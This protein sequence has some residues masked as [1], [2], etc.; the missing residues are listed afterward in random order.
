MNKVKV[1]M[2]PY[3]GA[4]SCAYYNW[5]ELF[6]KELIPVFIELCGRGTREYESFYTSISAASEDIA[7][8]IIENTQDCDYIIFGH[9]MGGLITYET[10]YK[11][12][13]LHWKK[14]LHLF[15]SGQRPPNMISKVLPCFMY[16]DE[17]FIKLVAKYGGLPEE[18][19][20]EEIKKVFLPILRADFSI[21]DEYKVSEKK[22][23]VMCNISILYGEYDS[24]TKESE[25][26]YWNEY[27][28]KEIKFYKFN[29][30]H[31]FIKD[32]YP[33]IISLMEKAID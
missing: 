3:A 25:Q 5:K 22:E 32:S 2:I 9:S 18:F 12:M 20:D 7:K 19:Y 23:K 1:F 26:T 27:A 11:L 31:F 14:P 30:E 16:S 33:Q 24:N 8:L 28:G 10:Y 4:S 21:L 15:I 6:S 29:G 13:E 17:E